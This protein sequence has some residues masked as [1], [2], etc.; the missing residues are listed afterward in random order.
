LLQEYL[1]RNAEQ[2]PDKTALVFKD[3]RLS[4]R[5]IHALAGRTANALRALGVRRGDR[6]V[7]YLDNSIE[8]ATAVFG[9]IAADAIVVIVNAQTRTDRLAY[10]L[11]DCRARV[12]IVGPRLERFYRPAVER[13]PH[14]EH[15]LLVEPGDDGADDRVTSEDYA[16]AITTASP[17]WPVAANIPVDLAAIVYTSGSTGEPKGVM[18]THHN[19][20]SAIESISA[21]L[22]NVPEDVLLNV[23]PLSFDYGLYQWLTVCQCGATLVL[24]PSFNYPAA[25]I[26]LIEE[27]GIT[28]FPLVPTVASTLRQYEAKGLRLPGIRYVTSTAAALSP[29]HIETLLRLFPA[30]RLFSMYGLTEC[31]RVSYLP[32]ERLADKPDSVGTAIPGTECF[33]VASDGTKLPP[34]RVGELVVRGPHVMRGYWEKPEITAEWLRP[35]PDI[36]HEMWLWTGDLFKTDEEGFLYFIGRKDDIIKSRGEKVA[37]KEVENALYALPG[38]QDAAVVGQP[39]ESLGHAIRAFIVLAEGTHYTADQVIRHCAE[40]LEPFMVPKW[41]TFLSSVPKTASGKI[42]KKRILEHAVHA[43]VGGYEE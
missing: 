40:R 31:K 43:T 14:L 12:M 15:V 1:E 11:N 18:L 10:V 6:V 25:T 5:E 3:R 17:D 39:H 42:A 26:R 19:M 34:G 8:L 28:G 41:V 38:I 22:G 36:P 24:E 21:Y 4:W 30:A 9:V 32:P 20:I 16:R 35:S 29:T 23:L 27:E 37:P 2:V 7:L 33:V 13:A